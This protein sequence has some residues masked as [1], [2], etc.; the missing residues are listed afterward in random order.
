MTLLPG[1]VILTGTPSGVGF[2]RKPPVFLRP[3]DTIEATVE[4]IGTLSNSVELHE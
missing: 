4:G 3:G 1:T 2:T